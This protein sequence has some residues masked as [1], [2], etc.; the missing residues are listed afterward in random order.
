MALTHRYTYY[1]LEP[2]RTKFGPKENPS[3]LEKTVW[4][5]WVIFAPKQTSLVVYTV[6]LMYSRSAS[7]TAYN[8]VQKP[9]NS[10][11]LILAVIL[12]ASLYVCLFVC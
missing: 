10:V 2:F 4:P 5:F 3:L 8:G 6:S 7:T 9:P 12:S 1:T 11:S